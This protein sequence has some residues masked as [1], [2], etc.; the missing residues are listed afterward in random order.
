MCSGARLGKLSG[1]LLA[2]EL[3]AEFDLTT[4]HL[5]AIAKVWAK[6]Q[7]INAALTAAAKENKTSDGN[8]IGNTAAL[9]LGR[10][11]DLEWRAGIG[12]SSSHCSSLNAPFVSLKFKVRDA[13]TGAIS[14]HPLELSLAEFQALKGTF[15]SIGAQLDIA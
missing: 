9:D 11:V 14:V 8:S 15:A 2:Q 6:H 1:E 5:T 7:K 10:I 12:V 4:A 13:T 3:A